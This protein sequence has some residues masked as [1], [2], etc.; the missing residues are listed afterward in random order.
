[1]ESCTHEKT[2]VRDKT[3]AGCETE[4][5]TGDAYCQDCGIQLSQ[6]EIIPAKGHSWDEGVVTTPPTPSQTG[7]KTHTCTACGNTRVEILPAERGFINDNETGT[8]VNQFEYQEGKWEY[9]DEEETAYEK[10]NHYSKEAG[11]VCTIRFEGTHLK[12]Y[13]AKAPGHGIAAFSVDGGEETRVDCYAKKRSLPMVL[14]DTGLLTSG[15]HV[16]TV[17]VTG[18]KNDAAADC[19][20]TADKIEVTSPASVMNDSVQGMENLQFQYE[21]TWAPSQ[22]IDCYQGDNHW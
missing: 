7:V 12:Y 8:G 20:V 22:D 11:T 2:E 15:E 18:E 9:N 21:G 6:G 3:E 16:L 5:Y 14:F 4:G 19:Y 1:M 13:G 10:D 17:K